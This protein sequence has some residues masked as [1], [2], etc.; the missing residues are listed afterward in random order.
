MSAEDAS[1]EARAAVDRPGEGITR[2]EFTGRDED[3][4]CGIALTRDRDGRVVAYV[5]DGRSVGAWFAGS[6]DDGRLAL[7]GDSGEQLQGAI[8]AGVVQGKAEVAGQTI[9]FALEPAKPAAGLRR[10]LDPEQ[11]VECG[12]VVQNDGGILGVGMSD[13]KV[14][15]S[16][17]IDPTDIPGEDHVTEGPGAGDTDVE[18]RRV[19]GFVRC[20]ILVLRLSFLLRECLEGNSASC[21]RYGQVSG[22]FLGLDCEDWYAAP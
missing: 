16:Y 7:T 8:E 14:V 4:T 5:S 20:S 19:I 2:V 15:L 18:P 10:A 12:F 17:R 1:Q 21:D 13:G 9:A 3:G 22:T 6:T 11:S